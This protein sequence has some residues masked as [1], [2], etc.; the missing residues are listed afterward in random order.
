[1]ASKPAYKRILGRRIVSIEQ[2]WF[3]KETCRGGEWGVAAL[4]LDDGARVVLETCEREDQYTVRLIRVPK[5][6]SDG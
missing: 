1:M 6:V 5:E 2:T 3:P 4:V